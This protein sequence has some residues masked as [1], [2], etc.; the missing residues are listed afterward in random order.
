MRRWDLLEFI[1][2]KRAVL[3]VHLLYVVWTMHSSHTKNEQLQLFLKCKHFHHYSHFDWDFKTS[4]M[5]CTY[6]CNVLTCM[7]ENWIVCNCKNSHPFISKLFFV[8]HATTTQH[9][10]TLFAV[11]DENVYKILF[12][13][14]NEKC[15]QRNIF[16]AL[17]FRFNENSHTKRENHGEKQFQLSFFFVSFL[18]CVPLHNSTVERQ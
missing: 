6:A 18:L 12:Y 9:R 14:T 16:S 2:N 8:Q 15:E 4:H 10:S 1:W 5:K 17:S 7:S 3:Y 13:M 11:I